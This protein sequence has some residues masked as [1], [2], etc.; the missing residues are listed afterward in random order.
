MKK[1]SKSDLKLKLGNLLIAVSLATVPTAITYGTLGIHGL[2]VCNTARN[3][4]E[5]G[6]QQNYKR[7][8]D[9]AVWETTT[10][11]IFLIGFFITLPTWYWFYLCMKR[12]NNNSN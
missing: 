5:T 6:N 11:Y 10:R 3:K 9:E 7:I 8:C 1:K 12:K 4:I 2:S